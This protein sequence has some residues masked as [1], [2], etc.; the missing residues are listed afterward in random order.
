MKAFFAVSVTVSLDL[1]YESLI[2]NQRLELFAE[3]FIEIFSQIA[4]L[5]TVVDVKKLQIIAQ[6]KECN[7]LIMMKISFHVFIQYD[8]YS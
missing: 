4:F 2:Y 5:R 7:I 1:F 8:Y 6:R 3:S